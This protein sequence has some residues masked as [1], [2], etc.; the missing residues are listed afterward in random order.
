MGSRPQSYERHKQA[1]LERMLR[2]AEKI[3]PGLSQHL[4]FS[5]IGSPLTNAHYVAA[6]FGSAYGVEKILGNIGPFG[7]G[8]RSPIANLHLCGASTEGGHGVLGGTMGGVAAAAAQRGV[9]V[10]RLLS[11][12]P[13]GEPLTL[14]PSGA[15]TTRAPK[16]ARRSR[17]GAPRHAQL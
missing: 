15:G 1:I 4:V 6:P 10:D 12:S 7:Y 11:L 14:L 5:D 2:S 9:S 3:M 13:R 16:A 17:A 8:L